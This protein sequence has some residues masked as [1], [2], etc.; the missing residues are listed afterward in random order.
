MDLAANPER[1]VRSIECVASEQRMLDAGLEQLSSIL[2]EKHGLKSE[3]FIRSGREVLYLLTC[4]T[5]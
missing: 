5:K 1:Y 4:C 2:A 3:D